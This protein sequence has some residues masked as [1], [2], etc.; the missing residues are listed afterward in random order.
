MQVGPRVL[1]VGWYLPD[2]HM[3]Q[4]EMSTNS[5]PRGHNLQEICSVSTALSS[6]IYFPMS[7]DSQVT[8]KFKC[9]MG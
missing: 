6:K 8:D 7:H 4:N 5:R 1:S 2:V 9:G 3:A